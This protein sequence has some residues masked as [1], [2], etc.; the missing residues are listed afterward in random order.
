MTVHVACLIPLTQIRIE[1]PRQCL[2][3]QLRVFAHIQLRGHDDKLRGVEVVKPVLQL[4]RII[5]LPQPVRDLGRLLPC[6]VDIERQSLAKCI[7]GHATL[8]VMKGLGVIPLGL[9]SG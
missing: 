2:G 1:V 4:P 6:Q 7:L 9:Q 5:T 3:N 8:A